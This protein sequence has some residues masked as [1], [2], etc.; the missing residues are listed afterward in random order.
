MPSLFILQEENTRRVSEGTAACGQDIMAELQLAHR[1]ARE[2]ARIRAGATR[3][4]A[5][6][7]AAGRGLLVVGESG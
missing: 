2:K 4:M 3:I 7:P 1:E 6:A 5:R